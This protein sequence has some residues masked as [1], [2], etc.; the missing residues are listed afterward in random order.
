MIPFKNM[1]GEQNCSPDFSVFSFKCIG[2]KE[3]IRYIWVYLSVFIS[4]GESRKVL[5]KIKFLGL[6]T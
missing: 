4:S 2:P 6:G 1:K 3:S 5:P